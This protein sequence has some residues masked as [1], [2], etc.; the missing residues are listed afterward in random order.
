MN[1]TFYMIENMILLNLRKDFN[2]RNVP[3]RDF[4]VG[5]FYPFLLLMIYLFIRKKK[6]LKF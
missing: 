4:L 1:S 5:Y 2:Q 6:N 3:S